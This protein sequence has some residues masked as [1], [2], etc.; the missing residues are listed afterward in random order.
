MIDAPRVGVLPSGARDSITDVGGVTVGHHTIAD[1]PIQTG[2]TVVRPHTGDARRYPVP[3][4]AV[5]IN[6]FG[7]TTG[8]MQLNE[9]GVLESPITLTNTFAVGTMYTAMVRDAVARD[10]QIGRTA[11]TLNPVV[12]ECNDGWLNDLQ[13][14]S[15][16][17]EH[18]GLAMKSASVTFAQGAAGAGRGM[19]CF[20]LKGG[21][22]STSRLVRIGTQTLS[23]GA[24]VLANFGRLPQLILCG[25]PVGRTLARFAEEGPPRDRGSV[26]VVI[27]TDASLD[28]RQLRRL[29][30]RASA[31]I[32][33]TGSS[34][35]HGSGDIA[36]AFASRPSYALDGTATTS[37]DVMNDIALDPLFDATA[38][39]TEQAIVNGLF[40]AE[41]VR[42]YAG[43]ERQAIRERL[44]DWRRLL[45][46]A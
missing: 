39:A 19:S 33:R 8:L 17:E 15:V 18:Y 28:H 6:G 22:G 44:P 12:A 5:V 26:I 29:A 32:A 21:I 4:A 11:P 10:P 13:T 3:A 36:I 1:G 31:G 7:K 35:G 16:T 34:F 43:H 42:G 37:S 46:S 2:V 24:L 45:P 20:G 40:A 41:T 14:F 9:L 27:A 25:V 30:T 38:E 23:V